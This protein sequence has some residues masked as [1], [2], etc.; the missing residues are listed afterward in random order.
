MTMKVAVFR[1]VIPRSLVE[2]YRVSIPGPLNLSCGADNMNFEIL[3]P[4]EILRM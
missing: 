2:M 4:F 1:D 3:A